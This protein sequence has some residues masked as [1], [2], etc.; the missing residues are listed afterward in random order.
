MI[1]VHAR[2]EDR[3]SPQFVKSLSVSE[4]GFIKAR[5]LMVC[6]Q[7]REKFSYHLH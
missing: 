3:V 4:A 1:A 2:I 7:D 6:Q 5:C